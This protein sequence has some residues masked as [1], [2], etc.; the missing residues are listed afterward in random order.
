VELI[1]VSLNKIRVLESALRSHKP[2][3]GHIIELAKDILKRGLLNV[4]TLT[5]SKEEEGYYILTDGARRLCA[6]Q[7][8]LEQGKI[9]EMQP[10]KIKDAQSELETLADQIA[11]N[12]Q[13]MKT[14][15][16][17]YIE[18][19]FKLASEGKMSAKKL[20]DKAG[21]STVYMFKL[22]KTLR[23]PEDVLAQAEAGKVSVSNLI[24]LS[25]LVGKVGEEDLLD[26]VERAKTEKAKDFSI[27]V[28]EEVDIIRKREREGEKKEPVFELVP[29]LLSKEQLQILRVQ[30][31][32][33]FNKTPNPVNEAK[34]ELMKLIWQ[35]DEK[36][37]KTQKDEWEKKQA[38]KEQSK[39]DRKKKR[40]EAK[41]ED[42]IKD[43][44]EAGF[45]VKPIK[46]KK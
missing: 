21:M 26:W 34:N 20:A 31:E 40:E 15:N 33:A 41:L 4:P 24:S 39:A 36:S 6:L 12:V 38:E 14:T 29:K 37:A 25:D 3:E 1:T 42:I 45:E 17:K 28:V 5:K 27:H 44:K 13:S 8:L 22:F 10:F 2:T 43:V 35:I 16:R 19:L 30:Y 9:D 32:N 18:A 23:L 11:G 46:P 7:L